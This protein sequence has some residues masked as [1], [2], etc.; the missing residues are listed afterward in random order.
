MLRSLLHSRASAHAWR[1][2]AFE[3]QGAEPVCVCPE[4][5]R[6]ML[7]GAMLWWHVTSLSLSLQYAPLQLY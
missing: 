7:A 1:L 3:F 5:K 4:F 6:S 2:V